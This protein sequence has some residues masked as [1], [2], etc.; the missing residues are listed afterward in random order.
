MAASYP[1][2]TPCW[3]DTMSSGFDAS[4]R[5]Y[6]GLLGWEAEV[7]THPELGRYGG[8]T[9]HGEPV[10][11]LMP[12]QP[13]NPYGDVWS[14]YIA[15]DDV[16]QTVAR[17]E[18]AGGFIMLPPMPVA[19][20]GTVAMFS[21]PSGAVVGAWQAGAHAGFDRSGRT[22]TPVWFEL[23]TP[24][25]SRCVDFYRAV[26]GWDDL[27]TADDAQFRY[28]TFTLPGGET[29]A[30]ILDTTVGSPAPGLRADAADPT[31]QDTPPP[32]HWDVYFAV[33]DCDAAVARCR[34]LGGA[35]TREPADSPYGRIAGVRDTTGAR[36]YVLA[37][38]R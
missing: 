38:G 35:A 32:G 3:I 8:F 25:F 21:D 36:F 17:A 20:Q 30:G 11:G 14:L 34:E 6:S 2:G 18:D 26:F 24:E 19:D 33:D 16:A 4:V 28:S 27:Q 23:R 5:F 29:V 10:A 1:T 12:Q 13:G 31:G 15:T 37:R 7:V 9:A 22:G